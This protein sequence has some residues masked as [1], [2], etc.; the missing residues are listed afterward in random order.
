M[1]SPSIQLRDPDT[2]G[3]DLFSL[4]PTTA[5]K[6]NIDTELPILQSVLADLDNIKDGTSLVDDPLAGAM[7]PR[8]LQP[9]MPSRTPMKTPRKDPDASLMTSARSRWTPAPSLLL[10]T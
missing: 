1:T 8:R 6:Y 10:L 7:G 3:G 2:T 9:R 5:V 4:S